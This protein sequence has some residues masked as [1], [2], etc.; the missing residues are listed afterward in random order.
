[1]PP[2]LARLGVILFVAACT[3]LAVAMVRPVQ[4]ATFTVTTLD[5]TGAGSLRQAIIDANATPAADTI[6]FDI[7]GSLVV[8]SIM[9][10]SPLP[11]ITAPV[12]IDG[13]T[14]PGFLTAPVVEIDGTNAGT[15]VDGLMIS[16][17]NSTIRG[18]I[19]NRFSN[20]GIRLMTNGGNTIAGNTIG[21]DN[22]GT[23]AQGNANGIYI[24]N[25]AGNT[26]GG[27]TAADRNVISGN[28]TGVWIDGSG[29]T[30]NTVLGNYI[31]TNAAGNTLITGGT[32]RVL[33]QNDASDN[34]IGGSTASARNLIAGAAF[35]VRIDTSADNNLVQGNFI[36]TGVNGTEDMGQANRG[37]SVVNASGNQIGGTAPGA[38]NL[39]AWAL[40][41]GDIGIDLDSGSANTTVQGNRIGTS[42]DGSASQPNFIGVRAVG[43]G[44][45]IGGTDPGAGNLISGN[46]VNG[47][48]LDGSGHTV[49]GN[50]IGTNAAGTGAVPNGTNG[51]EIFGT[52]HTIGGTTLAARNVIAGNTGTG[53]VVRGSGH[54][55]YGNYVGL[56]ADGLN[57]VPNGRGVDMATAN[58]L[59][60]AQPGMANVI[61]GNSSGGV[62]VSSSTAVTLLGNTIGY[63]ATRSGPVANG[64]HG[65]EITSGGSH[66]IGAAGAGNFIAGNLRDGVFVNSA[67]STGNS[68]RYNAIFDNGELGID[69]APDNVTL[70]D[71]DDPDVGANDL[72]NFPVLSNATL[73]MGQVT[74]TGALDSVPST[75]FTLQFFSSATCDLSGYGE[76]RYFLGEADVTTDSD[77][78]TGFSLTFAPQ[79][80]QFITATA[81][82]PNGSTSEFSA[83]VQIASSNTPTN[84]PT[85][86]PTV[87]PTFT[88]T[89][90]PMTPTFVTLTPSFTPTD[91]PPTPTATATAEAPGAT[92]L[93]APLGAIQTTEPVFEWAAVPDAGW[94]QFWLTG[95]DEQ[96]VFNGWFAFTDICTLTTCT[97]TSPV[98]LATGTHL[99]W[100]QT[101]SETG[102]FGPWTDAGMFNVAIAPPA[103]QLLAPDG[104][105]TGAQPTFT[106][107]DVPESDWFYLWIGGPRGVPVLNQWF[108]RSEVN[109]DGNTCSYD[110]PFAL[111]GGYHRWWIQT[112]SGG[113]YGEW[114]DDLSFVV[115]LAPGKPSLT[116]PLGTISEQQPDFTWSGVPDAGWYLVWVSGPGGTTILDQW[117]EGINICTAD[118][119]TLTMPSAALGDGAYRWWVQAWSEQSPDQGTLSDPGDFAV[120]T[121]QTPFDARPPASH[122]SPQSWRPPG[123]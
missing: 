91:A 97:L 59:G 89:N 102:G 12:T 63:S 10:N 65:V 19:I 56:D 33:I 23:I 113:V 9:L 58:T 119:C 120:L 25:S 110:L 41:G 47:L 54:M 121:G 37:I 46:T 6:V 38:G 106:W 61:S 31:G 32:Y 99:W 108:M 87:T 116:A 28:S 30:G 17:G 2:R 7:P 86:T 62:R 85:F 68:I 4:A 123:F 82:N 36:G 21:L 81:T 73:D 114:S 45:M 71:P 80:G 64:G 60:G 112:Y 35:G 34:T 117:Y 57:A 115:D 51:I 118:V 55:I 18:L 13:T 92:T 95:P 26:I 15:G 69:L 44:H 103:A 72:Q 90:T 42:P 49:Q 48:Q 122:P 5:D 22:T 14:Q 79:L 74:I 1:M 83:C 16:A 94:Y 75:T 101:W 105:I 96:L 3:A 43:S 84:S 100:V 67:S 88:P 77:G 70:N 76:G 93:I 24:V 50:L 8:Y 11:E 53:M 20:N 104:P 52:G 40:G 107:N 109:C 111:G 66:Q 39:V 29:A 98:T 27:P 78:D